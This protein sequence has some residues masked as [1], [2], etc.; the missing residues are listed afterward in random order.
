MRGSYYWLVPKDQRH[1]NW[2]LYTDSLESGVVLRPRYA[3]ME[4]PRCRKLDETTAIKLKGI[5]PDVR[6]RAKTDYLITDD[7]FICVSRRAYEVIVDNEIGGWNV[8]PLPGDD[9]YMLALP[10]RELVTDMQKVGMKFH[11]K[12]LQC[13]RYRET[14]GF[15][16]LQSMQ[17]PESPKIVCC[18]E[19]WLENIRGRRFW[20]LVHEEIVKIFKTHRLTGLEYMKAP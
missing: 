7:G 5:D 19:V 9:R 12:C 15:P 18:S 17:L 6:I 10:E 8:V 14:C 4:C 1:N 13:S 20:F 16:L 3:G 2:I 11:V